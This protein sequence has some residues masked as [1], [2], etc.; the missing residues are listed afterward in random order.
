MYPQTMQLQLTTL[1]LCN[2]SILPA[3]ADV[4]YEWECDCAAFSAGPSSTIYDM[5]QRL[6]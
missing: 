6:K 4:A 1:K 2:G 5:A 3:P